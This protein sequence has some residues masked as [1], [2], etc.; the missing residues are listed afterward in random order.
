M[1]MRLLALTSING[2]GRPQISRR[3]SN[4][5][6]SQ[7]TTSDSHACLVDQKGE[8][9]IC[10]PSPQ[11]SGPGLPWRALGDSGKILR[12]RDC[13]NAVNFGYAG[14]CG[15]TSPVVQDVM[16]LAGLAA[17]PLLPLLACSIETFEPSHTRTR[18]LQVNAGRDRPFLNGPVVSV[19]AGGAAHGEDLHRNGRESLRRSTSA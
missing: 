14:T 1:R 2:A 4:R 18:T 12:K 3:I 19:S 5:V 6:F 7:P 10:T 9:K 13:S 8:T 17:V 11:I 15:R 16:S